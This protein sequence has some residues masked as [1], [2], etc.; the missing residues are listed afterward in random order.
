MQLSVRAR[1]KKYRHV[2][3]HGD[4]GEHQLRETPAH[5]TRLMPRMVLIAPMSKERQ[6]VCTMG[7][8]S[9]QACWLCLLTPYSTV[10]P[11]PTSYKL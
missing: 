6:Q 9:M 5:M 4:I 2:P 11:A 8:V 3:F 10:P 1:V 7:D